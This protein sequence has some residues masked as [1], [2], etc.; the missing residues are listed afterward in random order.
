MAGY[1]VLS[2]YTF[3]I[4]RES[5]YGTAVGSTPIGLPTE[6]MT[7][8]QEPNKHRLN[9]AWGYRGQ[10]EANTWQDTYG[11]VPTASTSVIMTPQLMTLMLPGVLQADVDWA[12]ATS[13]WTMYTNNYADLPLP[14]GADE[15]YFYTLVRNSPASADDERLVSA[16]PTS[17]TLSIGPTDNEG[18]L[19][20]QWEFVASQ[21]DREVDA[22]GTISHAQLT[23]MYKWGEIC[24]VS[25]VTFGSVDLTSDFVS[26][27][28]S[29][30]NG[31]KLVNDIPDG[32][33]V[34]PKWEVTAT[35]TV[36]ANANTEGIKTKVLDR[37]VNLAEPLKIC[38]GTSAT[39]PAAEGDLILTMHAYATEWSSDYAEGEV[40]TFTFEGVFGGAGEYPFQAKF[41]HA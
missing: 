21:Y 18:I 1:K 10:H 33:F 23:D 24:T 29:I 30:T 2:D 40:I 3:T 7:F 5:A 6:E 36:I 31:A 41:Y 9:R 26:A 34:F 35:V 27:E 39:T 15:G 14:K 22:G 11:V 37:D 13:V 16:I 25:G 38:F 19:M 20:S 12:A 28:I 8:S 32:E 17:L 4:E